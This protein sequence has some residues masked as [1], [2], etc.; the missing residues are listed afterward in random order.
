MF[1]LIIL[2]AAAIGEVATTT[3]YLAV[4]AL[5]ALATGLVSFA[6]ASLVLQLGVFASVALVGTVLLRPLVLHALGMDTRV[7]AEAASARPDIV[8]RRG[9]VTRTVDASGGQIRIGQGEFWS[10]R[11]Y[12]PDDTIEV[13]AAVDIL[14]VEGLTALVAAVA[15][16]PTRPILE[17]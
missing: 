9:V 15:A 17:C 8:G 13:G 3:L 2:I 11:P 16:Q 10:A 12:N 6:G 5:A 14:L 1:W 7:H 4:V